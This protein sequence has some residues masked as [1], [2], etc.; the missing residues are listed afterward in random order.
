MEILV[1]TDPGA[2]DAVALL[3]TLRSPEMEVVGI[4]TV[5][6]NAPVAVTTANAPRVLEVAGRPDIPV[7][8]GAAFPLGA[9]PIPMST[10]RTG[11][12]ERIFRCRPS[13]PIRSRPPF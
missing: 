9:S 12:A 13:S 8:R 11:W 1:D 7:A 4:A 5:F 2:D 6:G 3:L 10:G